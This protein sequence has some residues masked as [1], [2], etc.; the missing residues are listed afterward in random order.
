MIEGCSLRKIQSTL[1]LQTMGFGGIGGTSLLRVHYW[2]QKP[3]IAMSWAVES[4]K[5]R[6]L[7]LSFSFPWSQVIMLCIIVSLCSIVPLMGEM[8]KMSP[9]SVLLKT[10]LCP[11]MDIVFRQSD[12]YHQGVCPDTCAEPY[13]LVPDGGMSDEI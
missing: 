8:K 2:G 7:S 6:F 3:Q 4:R 9:A 5:G 13:D 1:R 11:K 12:F 10:V